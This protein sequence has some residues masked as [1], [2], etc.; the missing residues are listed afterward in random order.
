MIECNVHV[1]VETVRDPEGYKVPTGPCPLLWGYREQI[2]VRVSSTP[3][4]RVHWVTVQTHYKHTLGVAEAR[5]VDDLEPTNEFRCTTFSHG[6][7]QRL[8]REQ[9][10]PNGTEGCVCRAISKISLSLTGIFPSVVVALKVET[11][12][13]NLALAVESTARYQ[14][15]HPSRAAY[16]LPTNRDG[17]FLNLDQ[18][19]YWV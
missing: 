6:E 3:L 16:I 15:V 11:R 19:G 17:G 2:L 1:D 18:W 10:K 8:E 4:D 12:A 14:G 7:Q 13:V 9:N 5:F